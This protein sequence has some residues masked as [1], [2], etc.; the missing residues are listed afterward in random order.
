LLSCAFSSRANAQALTAEQ[1]FDRAV[2]RYGV[3]DFEGSIATLKRA[4]TETTSRKRLAKI[5]LYLGVNHQVLGNAKAAHQA[6]RAALAHDPSLQVDPLRFKQAIIDAVARARAGMKGQL[7]VTSGVS[8]AK[9]LVDRK[10]A[11]LT[12]LRLALPVGPHFVEV[13]APKGDERL[14][15]DVLIAEGETRRV[16]AEWASTPA[17]AP[18]LAPTTRPQVAPTTT[19]TTLPV[20]MV[21]RNRQQIWTWVSAGTALVALGVGVGFGLSAESDYDEYR[22]EETSAV[23]GAQLARRIDDKALI[24]NVFLVGAGALAITSVVLFFTERRVG[25]RERVLHGASKNVRLT[26]CLGGLGVEGR[27]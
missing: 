20:P 17:S 19:P 25:G 13:R 8:G 12:P 26:L 2:T 4:R 27:F 11:G 6:F 16:H 5:A 23:R 14:F 1:L 9:V 22:A 7:E 10:L 24:S 3:A 15:R 21:P 18:R